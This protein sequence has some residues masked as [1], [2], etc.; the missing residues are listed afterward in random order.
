MEAKP[1][2]W[3]FR[4][5]P[6]IRWEQ[7]QA[8]VEINT[9]GERSPSE[10]DELLGKHGFTL[11]DQILNDAHVRACIN[12]KK[13]GILS[14]GWRV[15][16]ADE[17]ALAREAQQFVL[18]N[19]QHMRGGVFSLLW[20]TLD[21]LAKG[22]AVLEK[23]YTRADTPP[24]RGY[25]LLAGFKS[26]DPSLFS[27]EVD[28]YRNIRALL[29]HTPAGETLSLPREK[30]ILYAYNARYESPVGESDLKAVYPHWRA[31]Q[32][33][34]QMW[35]LFL[36]KYASPTLIGSYKRTL[37]PAQQ[38]ALL[39]ALDRVQQETA[40]VV[41]EDVKVEALDYKQG[42]AD[43]YAQAITYH[44]AEIAKAI[45]G[46]TL[47]TDEGQR[48]GSLAL[49]QV[50]LKVLQTQLRALRADLAER[51]MQEQV[52]RPLIQINMPNA[53][54]PRFVWDES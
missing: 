16:P 27:F 36:A 21:A 5:R 19:L 29:L 53:P 30:F 32:R 50:H 2:R 4:K 35:E 46:E 7:E 28:A 52:I 14:V 38:D 51:V 18:Y 12:L 47:T 22:Y 40:I 15:E 33:I 49:G 43:S 3:L 20:R 48:V 26:K 11:Y 6:Q 37:P 39:K 31:K 8:P 25:Y 10:F 24:Y 13:L 1:M 45:L 41:P 44:N 42:G 23:L 9:R 17:S 54:E 34:L